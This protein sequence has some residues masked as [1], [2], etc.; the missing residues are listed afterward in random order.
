MNV[1]ML[2]Q[3][4]QCKQKKRRWPL[5]AN[6]TNGTARFHYIK[7]YKIVF[8]IR[9]DYLQITFFLMTIYMRT[10]RPETIFGN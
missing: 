10:L 1:G 7:K 9:K 6:L 8:K 4:I 3:V 5:L 2:R